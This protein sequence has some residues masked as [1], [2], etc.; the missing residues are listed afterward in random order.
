MTQEEKNVSAYPISEGC[1]E[2][3]QGMTL[4]DYFA[5]MAMQPLISSSNVTQIT[6]WNR[7]LIL[8][9]SSRWKAKHDINGYQVVGNAY[10][11]AD[12]MLK[13]RKA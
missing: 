3:N 10:E 9:G 6:L 2:G 5:A 8:F 11:I 13:Y 1:T 7:I 4:R 12:K